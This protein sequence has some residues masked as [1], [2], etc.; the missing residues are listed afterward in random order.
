MPVKPNYHR[1]PMSA[2]RACPL[3]PGQARISVKFITD[4][5]QAASAYQSEYAMWEGLFRVA[6]ILFDHPDEQPVYS[7]I[8]DELSKQNSDGDFTGD[9]IQNLQIARAVLAVYEYANSR[10]ALKA[11]LLFCSWIMSH[12]NEISSCASIRRNPADLMEFLIKIY[13]YT[14]KKPILSLC[15]KLRRESVNWTGILQTYSIKRPTSLMASWLEM[16]AGIDRE[17]DADDGQYVRQ[18]LMT[19]AE[20]LADGMRATSMNAIFSGSGDELKAAQNGWSKISHWHGAIC[21]GTTADEAVQGNDP[22]IAIDAASLCAWTE[23]FL[24]QFMHED[25]R[26][27]VQEVSTLLCNALPASIIGGKLSPYQRVNM[28]EKTPLI[29]ECYHTHAPEE[30]RKRCLIRLCRVAARAVSNAVMTTPNGLDVLLY[31]SGEY[32][33]QLNEKA[34]RVSISHPSDSSIQI[35][36][37]GKEEAE[38]TLRLFIPEWMQDM[39]LAVNGK[40]QKV[41]AKNGAVELHGNW[42]HGDTITL[43][44]VPTVRVVETFHQGRAV[45]LGDMLMV[46]DVS[47]HDWKVAMV[48]EPRI[49][50]GQVHVSVGEVK[51]WEQANG[52]TRPLPV[53]PKISG[54]PTDAVLS[55]YYATPVR[56][57]VFPKGII[58]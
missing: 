28:V 19:H 37:Q 12:W 45:F 18:Y 31:I 56:L 44:W 40:A 41:S 21:G 9:V 54:E 23:A 46:L 22:S 1:S 39:Q 51:N 35:M 50:D 29:R 27:A 43:V 53:R 5:Y 17:G 33:L 15:D 30:Q 48:G 34:F 16:R 49:E 8:L 20:T 13:W 58:A 3:G 38:A 52:V 32:D 42:H 14:G 26:W 11:L 55:P 2:L 7:L 36:L 24:V 10:D 25:S 6:C 4:M 47:D 57:C